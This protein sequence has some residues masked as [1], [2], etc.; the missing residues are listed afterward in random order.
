MADRH[1]AD[2]NDRTGK[3][4]GDLPLFSSGWGAGEW[5]FGPGEDF[6]QRIARIGADSPLA[7]H[8]DSAMEGKSSPRVWLIMHEPGQP[9]LSTTV[10]LAFARELA[11][12]DQAALVLDCDDQSQDLTRW[13]ERVEAEGWIDLARYGTSILTSGVAMPF[14][15]R[16][17]YL[18]GV[19]SFAPTDVTAEEIKQTVSRLRRQADDLILVAPADAIGELWAPVAGIRLLCWDRASRP[20][21]DIEGLV[22]SFAEAGCPL[23]GL[24]GFGLPMVP[25]QAAEATPEVAPVVP[26]EPEV[27]DAVSADDFESPVGEDVSEEAA[28]ADDVEAPP[29]ASAA[30]GGDSAAREPAETRADSGWVD[31][32]EPES[33]EVRGRGTSGL[34]WF[35]AIAAVVTVGIMGAYWFKYSRDV[36]GS[37]EVAVATVSQE[38]PAVVETPGLGPGDLANQDDP[39]TGGE[40]EAVAP[41]DTIAVVTGEPAESGAEAVSGASGTDQAAV[42]SEV[43]E[44]PVAAPEDVKPAIGTAPAEPGFSM[45]PYREPVGRGGWALHLYSFPNTKGTEAEVAELHR[46][47][48]TTEVRV[49]ETLAKGRWWRVYVGSFA[50]KAEARAAAPLLKEKLRT[51]W[52]NPT[53][54]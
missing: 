2:Q 27:D 43:V 11:A 1:D 40:E 3:I 50:S 46:R 8:M 54:F 51:D 31:A 36:P 49:V 6:W 25:G 34:F 23:T 28:P 44:K 12:R 17:G 19:G 29:A 5:E 45:A 52:A 47:G 30:D 20:A 42:V 10:A 4:P 21:A 16:R 39:A 35:A 48:F 26:A 38:P 33:G 7:E 22:A 13:A 41:I 37:N 32:P 18:L 15:G 24:V 9:E 53:R 14:D